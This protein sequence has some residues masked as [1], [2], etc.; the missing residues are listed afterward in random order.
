VKENA[1]IETV[2]QTL[3]NIYFLIQQSVVPEDPW[4]KKYNSLRK[5]AQKG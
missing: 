2:E 4:K 3:Q 5:I 1:L